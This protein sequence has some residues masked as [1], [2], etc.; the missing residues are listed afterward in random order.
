MPLRYLSAKRAPLRHLSSRKYGTAMLRAGIRHRTVGPPGAKHEVRSTNK[1]T[2]AA[3]STP[4]QR[5]LR[6]DGVRIEGRASPPIGSG[7]RAAGPLIIPSQIGED[8]TAAGVIRSQGVRVGV[9]PSLCP[10]CP[11][12]GSWFALGGS[13]RSFYCSRFVQRTRPN[14]HREA[15]RSRCFETAI[16]PSGPAPCGAMRRRCAP[17]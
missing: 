7:V 1:E 5:L 14:V 17:L 16:A 11:S 3:C 9:L 8:R 4:G 10:V 2:A 15:C 12:R 6:G 13:C